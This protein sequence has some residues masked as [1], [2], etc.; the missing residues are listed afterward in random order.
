M[1]VHSWASH[2]GD[3]NADSGTMQDTNAL[4]EDLNECDK[5]V[6]EKVMVEVYVVTYISTLQKCRKIQTTGLMIAS[7]PGH[8]QK[9][10]E[11]W[12]TLFVQARNYPRLCG[13]RITPYLTIDYIVGL[14]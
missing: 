10:E 7:Y 4:I 11:A 12:Y 9:K 2:I 8:S 5:L 1:C 14:S 6:T 3:A 13:I